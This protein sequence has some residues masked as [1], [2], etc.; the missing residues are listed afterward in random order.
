M[1]VYYIYANEFSQLNVEEKAGIRKSVTTQFPRN[2]PHWMYSA[3]L[4]S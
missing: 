2:V 1:I 3:Y 4:M